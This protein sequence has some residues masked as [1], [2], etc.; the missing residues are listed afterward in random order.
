[1]LQDV[2]P[3]IRDRDMGRLTDIARRD[4]AGGRIRVDDERHHTGTLGAIAGQKG[5]TI[6]GERS[7]LFGIGAAGDVVCG[8]DA[9]NLRTDQTHCNGRA[10]T[11]ARSTRLRLWD[12][13]DW[14][15]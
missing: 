9:A 10:A 4:S 12:S 5:G 15:D 1:M 6:E 7:G 3:A 11:G 14:G 8:S 13:L 2:R